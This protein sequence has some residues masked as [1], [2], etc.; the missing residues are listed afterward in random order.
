MC[1]EGVATF[2]IIHGKLGGISYA[3]LSGLK[4]AM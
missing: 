4:F 1:A 2:Y 3:F